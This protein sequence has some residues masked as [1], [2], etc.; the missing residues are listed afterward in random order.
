[1]Y[2]GVMERLGSFASHMTDELAHACET[3]S[4]LVPSSG[5]DPW[6]HRRIIQ[7]EFAHYQE[8]LQPQIVLE[9]GD[10]DGG[11]NHLKSPETPTPVSGVQPGTEVKPLAEGSADAA[12]RD[13]VSGPLAPKPPTGPQQ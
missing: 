10:T 12:R 4:S 13:S 8:S 6:H 1:M 11:T 5:L 7:T 3:S 2:M 9:I